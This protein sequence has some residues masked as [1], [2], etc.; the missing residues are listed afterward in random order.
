MAQSGGDV[1]IL[2]RNWGNGVDV[3]GELI[4]LVYDEL[5]RMARSYLQRERA[6]H[7]LQPT[8]LVNEAYMRL[9]G[10]AQLQ[11]QCRAHFFGIAST[12]M[13]RILVEHARARGAAKR[14]SGVAMETLDNVDVGTDAGLGAFLDLH[15][16]LEELA[17]LDERKAR[18]VELKYFGG[19]TLEEISAAAGISPATAERDLKFSHAWLQK[20]LQ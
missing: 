9:V 4:P 5:R 16:A 12:A 13:R 3:A 19:L 15:D 20:R 1:T 6:S 2:L 17:K 8:A 14:G 18:V 7:T 10:D 11:P